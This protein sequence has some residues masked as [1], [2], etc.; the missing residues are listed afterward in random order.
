MRP[1]L[2][3]KAC[4]NMLPVVLCRATIMLMSRL[5]NIVKEAKPQEHIIVYCTIMFFKNWYGYSFQCLLKEVSS[6]D[7]LNF[8]SLHFAVLTMFDTYKTLD[9]MPNSGQIVVLYRNIYLH[10]TNQSVNF[11]L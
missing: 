4:K 9:I 11:L 7:F 8:V 3:A 10:L 5:E 1:L 2:L 6:L